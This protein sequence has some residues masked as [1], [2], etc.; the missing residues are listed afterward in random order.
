MEIILIVNLKSICQ[1]PSTRT[2]LQKLPHTHTHTQAH[3]PT[4]VQS[5]NNNHRNLSKVGS[6][7]ESGRR[8]RGK[9]DG[10]YIN[11]VDTQ[12]ILHATAVAIA[13]ATA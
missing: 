6:K 12:A 3:A 13:T 8:H 4:H 5:S 10:I 9:V 11:F 2:Q 1:I 7:Q